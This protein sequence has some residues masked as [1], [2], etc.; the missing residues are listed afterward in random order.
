[1]QVLYKYILRKHSD[2][3]H[4]PGVCIFSVLLFVI[5]TYILI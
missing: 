1:M 4:V 5:Y 2:A 3:V